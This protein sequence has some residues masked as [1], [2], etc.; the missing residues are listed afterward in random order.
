MAI[1]FAD[2]SNIEL[3]QLEAARSEVEPVNTVRT[4][5]TQTEDNNNFLHQW[6]YFI[7]EFN[8]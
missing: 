4:L 6:N 5:L 1:M 7:F 2:W 3:D 8:K